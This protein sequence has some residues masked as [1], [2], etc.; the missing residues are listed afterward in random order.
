MEPT[1]FLEAPHVNKRAEE[2]SAQH[3]SGLIDQLK[4]ATKAGIVGLER[5]RDKQ[6]RFAWME[7]RQPRVR[8]VLVDPT[9]H[10]GQRERAQLETIAY[11]KL[12]E[13]LFGS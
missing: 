6:A 9:R 7:A 12:R 8:A 3:L 13:E 2:L 11:Y 1:L 5:I 10:Q 4:T